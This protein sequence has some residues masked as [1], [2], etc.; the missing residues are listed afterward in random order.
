MAIQVGR[1]EIASSGLNSPVRPSDR[2]LGM[3]T[4]GMAI[5]RS[6]FEN[7]YYISPIAQNLYKILLWHVKSTEE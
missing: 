1:K 3:N 4:C 6:V 5:Q 2:V 7:S